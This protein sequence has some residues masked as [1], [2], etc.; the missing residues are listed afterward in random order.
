MKKVSTYRELKKH[1]QSDGQES[2]TLC[3]FIE[4]QGNKMYV[5]KHWSYDGGFPCYS[6]E[7]CLEPAGELF[8][9]GTWFPYIIDGIQQLRH[10]YIELQDCKLIFKSEK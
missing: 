10:G 1:L 8:P 6:D 5:R 3:G 2:G 4:F 9:D 7:T